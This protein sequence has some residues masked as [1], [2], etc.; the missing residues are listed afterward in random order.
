MLTLQDTSLKFQG[1]PDDIDTSEKV[2]HTSYTDMKQLDFQI[3]LA[4]NCYVNPATIHLCFPMKIKK[5][6]NNPSNIGN[7]MITV[8][9]FFAHFRK[10]TNVTKYGSEK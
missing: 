8:N 5:S 4:D 6:T 1:M 3:L 7:N 9:N 10:G 2:A